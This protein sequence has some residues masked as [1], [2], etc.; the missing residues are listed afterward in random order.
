MAI[1]FTLSPEQRELQRQSRKFAE[2]VL[3]RRQ[4]AE[5][6]ATPEERLF[7]HQAHL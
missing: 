4:A 3:V 1:D 5:A 7:C 2:E 6:F